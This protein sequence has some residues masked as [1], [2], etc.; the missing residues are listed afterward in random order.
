M[1]DVVCMGEL[2]IDFVPTESGL[3]LIDASVFK[4]APGGGPANVA[5]G[6]AR[7]GVRSAF[8]GRSGMMILAGSWRTRLKRMALTTGPKPPTAVKV[9]GIT[10]AGI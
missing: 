9:S 10:H 6:L 1:A 8:M 4:K 5:V 3:P 7:L 2:L